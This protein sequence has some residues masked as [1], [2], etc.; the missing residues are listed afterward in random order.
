MYKVIHDRE[1]AARKGCRAV[2]AETTSKTRA[3]PKSHTSRGNKL[4]F[5]KMKRFFVII[6]II[7]LVIVVNGCKSLSLSTLEPKMKNKY[8]LPSLSP[9]LDVESF[10]S[11]FGLIKTT[12]YG[13]V[14]GV[15][16]T[17][18]RGYGI[19]Y[20]SISMKSTTYSNPILNDIDV[21]FN[22][23][24]ENIC[25]LSGTPKGSIK[26]R[27]IVGKEKI[28]GGAGWA[29]LSGFTLCIPNLFGMPIMSPKCNLQ[30]EVTIF[31]NNNSVVGRYTSDFRKQ[32]TYVALYWGYSY[33]NSMKRNARLIFTGCMEDIKR[34][35]EKDYTR[36]IEALK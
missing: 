11:V 32:K 31:D 17:M 1:A 34:Q 24:V 25:H 22:R 35:I 19:G 15:S 16:K 13:S 14:G 12:G 28:Y 20:G 10:G 21:I 29:V 5:H 7:S 26:C 4:N 23:D 9:I 8:L 30:I 33:N 18:G 3:I 6:G 36:L 2:E 27:L